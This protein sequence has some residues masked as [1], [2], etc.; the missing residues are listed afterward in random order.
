MPRNPYIRDNANEQNLIEDLT[1][2]VIRAMGR[3]V[4]Y[5]PRKLNAQDA[6]YGEDSLSTFESAYLIEMYHENS[7][8]FGGEGDIVG[9]FGIDVR[10]T[11]AFRVARRTFNQYVT[12]RDATIVRPKE[13]DLIYYPLSDTLFE[14]TFVEHE[15]PLY[16]AGALYSFVVFVET[17]AYNNEIF[18]TGISEIDT[19]F[20]QERKKLA[21]KFTVG[22]VIGSTGSFIS[23]EKIYQVSG[24]YGTGALIANATG[25]ADVL[26]IAGNTLTVALVSGSFLTGSGAQSIVGDSSGAQRFLT[27][28]GDADF[29]VQFNT[30][31]KSTMGDNEEIDFEVDDNDLIDFSEVDP[32]SEGKY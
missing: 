29:S 4:Y 15:N 3:D 11:A 6:L 32:F 21:Q 9:K 1:V 19:S 30:V 10:D 13:G 28:T 16:Q 7:T 22:N 8:A 31:D 18:N 5:L 12:K 14:I 25:T 2:E 20:Q 26:D 27:A 17:F 24:T 23:G